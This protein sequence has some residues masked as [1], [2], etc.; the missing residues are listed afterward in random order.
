MKPLTSLARPS[1]GCGA[2]RGRSSHRGK[3]TRGRQRLRVLSC[4]VCVAVEFDGLQDAAD[5]G[6]PPLPAA[7]RG[8]NAVLV[9]AVG[10]GLQR[11][12]VVTE[13]RDSRTASG[14][15]TVRP[16]RSPRRFRAAMPSR[17]RCPISS[18][19]SWTT[20]AIRFATNR[21]VGVVVSTPKS[22][23]ISAQPSSCERAS[24][25]EKSR[26]NGRGDPASTPPGR[27]PCR[28]EGAGARPESSGG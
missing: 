9:Q 26:T 20:F 21:P 14:S 1:T 5:G 10:D 27:R 2:S 3:R 6:R 22:R 7:V 17:V 23:Q 11:L 15:S 24:S 18:R 28:G 12:A 4:R 25:V 19:S 8:R 13:S 16:S